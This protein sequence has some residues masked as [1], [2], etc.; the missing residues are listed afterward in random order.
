[1]TFWTE[2]RL[3]ADQWPLGRLNVVGA[4]I[5]SAVGW[6][7]TVGCLVGFVLFVPDI[8]WIE[9]CYLIVLCGAPQCAIWAG[10][11]ARTSM[12]LRARVSGALVQRRLHGNLD[13]IPDDDSRALRAIG[14]PTAELVA[15]TGAMLTTLV[16]RPNVHVFH[17]IRTRAAQAG[18]VSHVV[19]AGRVLI[20]IESIAW[21]AGRYE[22]DDDNR[23][24][25][26]GVYIG[27]SANPLLA[28]VSHWR[29]ALPHGHRVTALVVLHAVDA[30]RCALPSA[31]PGL[32]WTRSED[33]LASIGQQLPRRSSVSMH[34]LAALA[35]AT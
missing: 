27:Q 1:M 26:D 24:L 23:V 10:R 28:A 12:R 31:R 18:V 29:D 4:A 16:D 19:S 11:H 34:A 30:G 15:R 32:Q 21:P 8:G 5:V 17:A 20:L 13:S 7:V 33:L 25:C 35:E 2:R 3:Q 9:T 22:L 6:L 14:M